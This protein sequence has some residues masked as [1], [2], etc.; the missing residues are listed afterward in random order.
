VIEERK[1]KEPLTDLRK[2]KYPSNA[3]ISLQNLLKNFSL[4]KAWV[5]NTWCAGLWQCIVSKSA[6]APHR[7]CCLFK[8]FVTVDNDINFTLTYFTND[9]VSLNLSSGLLL[10]CC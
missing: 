6:A 10:K 2:G 8:V 5:C 4:S 7:I 9:V 1:R 3:A